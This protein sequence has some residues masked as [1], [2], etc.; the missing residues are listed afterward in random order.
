MHLFK[1]PD[2][3]TARPFAHL[4]HARGLVSPNRFFCGNPCTHTLKHTHTSTPQTH[5]YVIEGTCSKNSRSHITSFSSKHSC[6]LP[7]SPSMSTRPSKILKSQ[8]RRFRAAEV[9]GAH[10]VTSNWSDA[11]GHLTSCFCILGGIWLRH[12]KHHCNGMNVTRNV[13]FLG[14]RGFFANQFLDFARC[15]QILWRHFF[16]PG[17]IP[18]N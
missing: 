14:S 16:C 2:S 15:L 6:K 8:F 13:H 5:T 17:G 18:R 9:F 11:L 7:V 12:T 3:T 4:P 1:V 10:E